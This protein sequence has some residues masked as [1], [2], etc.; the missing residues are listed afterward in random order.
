MK[1]P[2]K[3]NFSKEVYEKWKKTLWVD[4]SLDE[5]MKGVILFPERL[6]EVKNF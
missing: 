5:E 6:E 3:F 2:L 1:H 4:K